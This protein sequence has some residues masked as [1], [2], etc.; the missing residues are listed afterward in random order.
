M[1]HSYA[2]LIVVYYVC[3]MWLLLYYVNAMHTLCIAYFSYV[4]GKYK[5]TCHSI[6]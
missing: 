6:V 1:I 4:E 3:F 2:I 5:S